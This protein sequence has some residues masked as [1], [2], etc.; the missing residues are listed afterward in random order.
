VDSSEVDVVIVGAGWAGMAAADHLARA[1]VSFVVLEASDH[2]GGRTTPL[3]FG[4][5]SV[6][7]FIFEQGSN[8]ICGT[9]GSTSYKV[10]NAPNPVVE[11]AKQEG[12]RTYYIPGA[13]DGNMSNYFAVFD[14][15][16]Q[17][18]DPTGELRK[19]AN[20]AL[21][22]LN[23]AGPKASDTE[24]VRHGLTKC[25]WNPSTSAEWA[26]DWAVAADE[27]GVRAPYGSLSG[28]LPDPT[29]DW[30]G[31]D[32]MLVV[33]QHPRGF[34]RL[35][36][37]MVRDTV[38]SGDPR[39]VLNAHVNKINWGSNGVTVQTKDGRSFK[40]KQAISTVSLGV[41]RKHHEEL[42]SP[43]LPSKQVS[44]LM[45]N[46][47]PMANLTHVLIQFPSVWWDDSLPAWVAAN[48]GGEAQQGNFTVW[49]NMNLHGMMP[50]SNT[51][52]SFLGEP[53]AT[54]YGLLSEGEV[55]ALVTE[56]LRAQNPKKNIPNAVAAWL[57]N[58]GNDPLFYGA[59][60]YAEPGVNWSAK[61]K[62]P[63]VAG[64][65]KVVQFAGEATC[66]MLDGYVHGALASGKQ[67]A[68]NYLHDIGKGPK[69]SSDD[70]LY[71]CDWY[72]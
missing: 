63:L 59:Y 9:G 58:W 48:A 35:I 53:E 62:A 30:W 52:L 54:K 60:A 43:S 38:P 39:V 21:E 49:H 65:K 64:S 70:E 72:N 17:N 14:E 51:L 22:C 1:N 26:M 7:N 44:V 36:D 6:G 69:P 68:A 2:T 25:G 12:L 13:T 67:A 32:D 20:D 29:Y 4:D 47:M 31:P 56:R 28:F 11:L 16:G 33:D 10:P 27:S 57:K 15:N 41:L 50:G 24:T 66:D 23:K 46:H 71:L 19:K 45:N 40:G 5:P 34:A 18:V 42:F 8:W 3:K 37:G 61:W 55:I